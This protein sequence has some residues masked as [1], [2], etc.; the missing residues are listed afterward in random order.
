MN[1]NAIA[2]SIVSAINPTI[3]VSWQRST[4]STLNADY[5]RTPTFQTTQIAVQ[6]Q[7]LSSN[8]L[9]LLD[10][11]NI[12]GV[13]RKV[14]A[15]VSLLGTDRLTQQGGDLLIFTDPVTSAAQTWLVTIVFE[16][17]D[18]AGPWSSVGLTLQQ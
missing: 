11:L 18:Q 12:Q 9:R 10:G 7:P 14:Y 15:N 8:D 2:G 13:T 17:W 4:G 1:L 6:E 5:T 16:T 3:T